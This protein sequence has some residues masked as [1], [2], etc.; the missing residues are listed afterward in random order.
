VNVRAQCKTLRAELS[1]AKHMRN[2]SLTWA[3]LEASGISAL[4]HVLTDVNRSNS[5]PPDCSC[6]PFTDNEDE[7]GMHKHSGRSFQG[8]VMD[9]QNGET[10]GDW[11]TIYAIENNHVCVQ[12]YSHCSLAL[13]KYKFH[14]RYWTTETVGMHW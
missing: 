5:F 9:R 7:I 12:I 14:I 2:D 4:F 8:Q 3:W 10:N 1:I 6:P 11:W 13:Q